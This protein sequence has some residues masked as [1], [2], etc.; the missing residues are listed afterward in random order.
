MLIN[1]ECKLFHSLQTIVNFEISKEKS[2]FKRW[3]LDRPMN[4][5]DRFLS[6]CR[7]ERQN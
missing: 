5:T 1:D 3:E 6:I 2:N 4:I 7:L